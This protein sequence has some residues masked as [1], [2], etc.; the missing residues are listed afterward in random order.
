MALM[1]AL[2]QALKITLIALA[3]VITVRAFH[4]SIGG[5]FFFLL[6]PF[7]YALLR[8]W[9]GALV[10]SAL[11]SA[12]VLVAARRRSRPTRVLLATA[13]IVLLAMTLLTRRSVRVLLP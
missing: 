8:P 13:L 10:T 9:L 12:A 11:A 4:E 6:L 2:D 3:V 7:G 1:V 5:G